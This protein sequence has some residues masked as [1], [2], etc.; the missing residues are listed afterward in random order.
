MENLKTIFTFRSLQ[1]SAQRSYEGDLKIKKVEDFKPCLCPQHNPPQN[2]YLEPGKYEY[3]CPT[4]GNKIT[5]IVP[6]IY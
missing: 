2:I 1:D 5:F 4:C 6:Y 3:T